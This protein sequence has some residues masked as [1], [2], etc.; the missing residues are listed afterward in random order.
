MSIRPAVR[1][2]CVDNRNRVLL[3]CWRDP[4]DGNLIWEPPGGGIEEG[5][6]PLDTARREL[7]EETGLPG[8]AVLP[9]P[10]PVHRHVRWNG[11]LYDG[12]EQFYLATFDTA[13][14]LTRDGLTDNEAEWLVDRTWFPWDELPPG[15]EP[16]E[17][18]AVLSQL[19]PTGPWATRPRSANRPAD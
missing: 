9:Q 16:P 3:M 7:T 18:V 13:P 1:V 10:V 11:N 19:A 8:A 4:T 12:T 2:I 15:V 6:H 14:P 5:E 17:L